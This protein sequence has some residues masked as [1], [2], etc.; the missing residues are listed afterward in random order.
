LDERLERIRKEWGKYNIIGLYQCHGEYVAI[1]NGILCWLNPQTGKS[2][3]F[4][5]REF[6]NIEFRSIIKAEMV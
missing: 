1:K 6:K 4:Y 5:Q 3:R 2:R